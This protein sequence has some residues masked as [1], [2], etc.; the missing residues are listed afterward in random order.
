[1]ESIDLSRKGLGVASRI[2]IAACIKEN[3]VL[4]ELN[5]QYNDLDDNAKSQLTQAAHNELKLQL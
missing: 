3:A 2:V 4:M 5:L 1:M